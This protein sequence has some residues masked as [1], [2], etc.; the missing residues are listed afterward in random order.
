MVPRG[1]PLSAY[2]EGISARPGALSDD[3]IALS[4]CLVASELF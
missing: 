4:A 2:F 3:L 1:P